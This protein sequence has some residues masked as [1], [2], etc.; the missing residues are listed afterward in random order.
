MLRFHRRRPVHDMEGLRHR[1]AFDE[2]GS[3]FKLLHRN[4]LALTLYQMSAEIEISYASESELTHA[5]LFPFKVLRWD[6]SRLTYG[7]TTSLLVIN[8][9][10]NVHKYE[11]RRIASFN[12]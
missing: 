1:V 12:N 10:G 3:S 5:V 9:L 2:R 8:D 6:Q 11:Y 7:Q 4:T